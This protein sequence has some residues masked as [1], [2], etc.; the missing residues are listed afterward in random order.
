MLPDLVMSY[1]S[2]FVSGTREKHVSCCPNIWNG[3][4]DEAIEWKQ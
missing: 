2:T 3:L 1:F 4:W